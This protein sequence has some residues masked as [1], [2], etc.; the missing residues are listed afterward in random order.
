MGFGASPSD[1]RIL[2]ASCKTVYRKC[3][4]AGGDY[5]EISREV[6]GVHT[7]LRHLKYETQAPE[8]PLN[9]DRSIWG[10]QLAPIA[11]DCDISLRQLDGLLQ[12]YGRL[13]TDRSGSPAS[14]GVSRDRI[15][16]GR[17]EL[18]QLGSI[19]VK[20]ISHKNNLTMFMDRIQLD[21]SIVMP[22]NLEN[23]EG[24]L[25]VILDKVDSIAARM[26]PTSA[27]VMGGYDDD[28]DREVWKQFRRE[29]VIEGF[30]GDILE[31]H[32][33]V[34]RAYIRELDQNGLLDEAP[35][36][37]KALP[38]IERVDS[39]KRLGSMQTLP[40]QEQSD[41]LKIATVGRGAKEIVAQEENMKFPLSMKL[42][43]LRPDRDRAVE[44]QQQ[45]GA[46]SP[47][48]PEHKGTSGPNQQ[49]LS[50]VLDPTIFNARGTQQYNRIGTSDSDS[51]T[52]RLI[53][54][55]SD[56]SKVVII[57]TFDL[58]DLSS[59]LRSWP[60][61]LPSSFDGNISL[62][63][64]NARRSI[65]Y[66]PKEQTDLSES[67]PQ[68]GSLAIRP[69]KANISRDGLSTSPRPE[70]IRLAPDSQGN[71]IP[72][73]AKWTKINRRLVSPEVFDQDGRRYEARPDFVAVL[74]VLSRKEIEEYTMRSQELR[75]ARTRR[76]QPPPPIRHPVPRLPS[77]RGGR[78]AR[79]TDED[80][81][82]DSEHYTTRRTRKR[83]SSP[84]SNAGSD[85]GTSSGYP[86]PFGVRPPSPPSPPLPP[87]ASPA[88]TAAQ[89]MW[90]P[91]STLD[92][93]ARDRI[94]PLGSYEADRGKS[95]SSFSREEKEYSQHH[96][97]NS[98]SRPS[99][100]SSSRNNRDG[101]ADK[102]GR[103]WREGAKAAG[104]GGAAMG[105]L[106]VLSDAAEGL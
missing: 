62:D 27:G 7:V 55:F 19:R 52:N 92:R 66:K 57:N 68:V 26:G 74:G 94:R 65:E 21:Q 5:D 54:R 15:Q 56:P 45:R 11:S 33:D 88:S 70:T 102:K 2:V 25:D 100:Y 41:S 67:P 48:L 10:R 31:Q 104:I 37:A 8:S 9:R 82:S 4:D 53:K 106:S 13:A 86:N 80:G 60:P 18:D 63:N 73:D 36:T 83:G 59:R 97:H 43:L 79:S 42:D 47:T 34:L 44:Y 40:G 38:S 14:T 78:L 89:P 6:K 105:L 49:Q 76:N 96:R 103:R 12:K 17:N 22:A 93:D 90:M 95:P 69:P 32:K 30:S 75:A 71:E 20:L 84:P 85:L 23:D 98:S 24:Q 61:G 50:P 77:E 58:L 64:D 87:R 35:S 101:E 28:D 91:R 51:D 81:S 72:P 1:I 29:L 46:P 3:R 16:F 39:A 99:S